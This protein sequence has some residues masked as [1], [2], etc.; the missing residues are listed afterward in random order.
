M[1]YRAISR[2]ARAATQGNPASKERKEKNQKPQK[3]SGCK[4]KILMDILY[5]YIRTHSLL[6]F[7][8]VKA[9]AKREAGKEN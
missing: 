2:T 1:V 9:K 3:I 6:P 5:A 8:T 4:N 7:Y